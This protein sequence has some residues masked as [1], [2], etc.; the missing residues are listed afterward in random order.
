MR[1]PYLMSAPNFW[2]HKLCPVR[3][4]AILELLSLPSL[5]VKPL[6]LNFKLLPNRIVLLL[7]K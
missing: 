1:V 3:N 6:E 2:H 4:H 5:H 7:P